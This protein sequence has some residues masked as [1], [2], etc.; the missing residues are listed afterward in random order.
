MDNAASAKKELTYNVVD[1]EAGTDE[2][3]LRSET[4][5]HRFTHIG[6]TSSMD[7]INGAVDSAF[8]G[9]FTRP[10]VTGLE[11]RCELPERADIAAKGLQCNPMVVEDGLYSDY[12]LSGAS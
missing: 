5:W 10:G 9:R 1:V 7:P 6:A 12:G 3:Q 4:M 8:E 11:R 2:R